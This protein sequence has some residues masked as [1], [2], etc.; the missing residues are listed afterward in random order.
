MINLPINAK[1]LVASLLLF[2]LGAAVG[3]G[4]LYFYTVKVLVPKY[5]TQMMSEMFSGESPAWGDFFK[6]QNPFEGTGETSAEDYVN[7]F[8]VIE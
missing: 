5:K 3:A 4:G 1:S 7:P 2:L 6:N 8:E